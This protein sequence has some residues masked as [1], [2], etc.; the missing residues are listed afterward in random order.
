MMPPRRNMGHAL[1]DRKR[2]PRSPSAFAGRP[3]K[4][5]NKTTCQQL[6]LAMKL[7]R[8][9]PFEVGPNDTVAA[10]L[11]CVRRLPVIGRRRA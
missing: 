1:D 5:G 7:K 8:E 9:T 10:M 2:S 4:S 3:G 6:Q 11:R